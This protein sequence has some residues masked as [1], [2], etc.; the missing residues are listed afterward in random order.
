MTEEKIKELKKRFLNEEISLDEYKQEEKRLTNKACNDNLC[1]SSCVEKGGKMKNAEKKLII[2]GIISFALIGFAELLMYY[3]FFA[4]ITGFS[5]YFSYI[6]YLT[7]STVFIGAAVWHIKH[8]RHTFDCSMGM[9]VGMTIGMMAGYMIGAVIG[10]TNGMFIGSVVGMF[11][12]MIIGAWCTRNCGVMSILEGLMAGLMGGLMG[13]MTAVMMINENITLFMPLLIG[14]CLLI[15]GGMSY[16]VYKES[17]EHHDKVAKLDNY[18]MFIYI[19]A[20]FIF[21]I[22]MTFIIAWGPRSVLVI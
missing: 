3:G 11:T 18:D 19:S 21:A 22:A 20:M 12:G 9:M 8:Y 16:M 15:T 1:S 14:A 10:A 6:F 5:K 2:V 13:A 4:A 7:I 17:R